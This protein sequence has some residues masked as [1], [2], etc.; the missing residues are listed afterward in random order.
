MVNS[1]YKD[2]PNG[3]NVS[4]KFS[5]SYRTRH[6]GTQSVQGSVEQ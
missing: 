1:F 5:P 3:E 2:V 6:V 4:G